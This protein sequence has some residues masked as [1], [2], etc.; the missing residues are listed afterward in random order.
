[1]TTHYIEQ[2]AAFIGRVE[3]RELLAHALRRLA[4]HETRTGCSVGISIIDVSPA[5]TRA[6]GAG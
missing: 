6:R 3:P 2:S 5:R 4:D 1:M